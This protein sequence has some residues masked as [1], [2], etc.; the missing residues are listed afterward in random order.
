MQPILYQPKQNNTSTSPYRNISQKALYLRAMVRT[1]TTN[2]TST[3][4]TQQLVE[5][6]ECVSEGAREVCQQRAA[7]VTRWLQAE[8][9]KEPCHDVQV[10]AQPL[11]AC[12]ECAQQLGVSS[13]VCGLEEEVDGVSGGRRNTRRGTQRVTEEELGNVTEG[14]VECG[15]G[16]DGDAQT[17]AM[18]WSSC[19]LPRLFN[20]CGFRSNLT[21]LFFPGFTR[22]M[23]R[24]IRRVLLEKLQLD[25]DDDDDDDEVDE[26]DAEMVDA[27]LLEE[28]TVL[29]VLQG[30]NK[31]GD[32]M[33]SEVE[34]EEVEEEEGR[35]REWRGR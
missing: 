33:E 31:P 13:A 26:A 32:K 9:H 14:V 24:E 19:F 30:K 35:W 4:A 11:E 22:K 1:C 12:S 25:D 28:A 16:Y 5:V 18:L 17:Q 15:S 27:G 6:G 10:D 29:T 8:E 2:T 34:E 20:T 3:N 21:T 23:D 7:L